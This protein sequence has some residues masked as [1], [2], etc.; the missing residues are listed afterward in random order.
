MS[1]RLAITRARKK[2]WASTS[3]LPLLEVYRV[4]IVS[5]RARNWGSR[6]GFPALSLAYLASFQICFGLVVAIAI[7]SL[8]IFLMSFLICLFLY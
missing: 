7:V 1:K 5:L 3:A 6:V 2:C 8:Y 4:P